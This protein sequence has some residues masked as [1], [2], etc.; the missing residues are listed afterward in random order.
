MSEPEG[1]AWL[2]SES[3]WVSEKV[4]P[5]SPGVGYAENNPEAQCKGNEGYRRM[6]H[7]L[8]ELI[9]NPKKWERRGMLD[10]QREK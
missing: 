1:I 6:F 8:D 5:L 2:P 7:A 9:L 4:P 10:L 3:R